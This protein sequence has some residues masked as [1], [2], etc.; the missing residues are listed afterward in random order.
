MTET[1]K[2]SS[3]DDSDRLRPIDPD[4][5]ALLAQSIEQG[6]L[7][8]PISVRA[9][10]DGYKLIVGGH[11]LA[12]V[13]NLGWEELTVGEHV[14]IRE[15][16]DD[17][18][19]RAEVDE[20]LVRH[21]LD[22]LDRALF[23]AKRQELYLKMA[24][25]RGRGGDRKS[26]KHKDEIKAQTLGFDFDEGFSANASKRFGLSKSA[27]ELAVG[28]AKKLSPE[29]IAAI[30]GT[31]V[32][33]NQ[34]ELL[35]L[36]DIKGDQQVAAAKLIQSGQAKTVSQAK[37]ALDPSLKTSVDLQGRLYAEILARLPKCDSATLKAVADEVK[38]EI[39]RKRKEGGE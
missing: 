1:I 21:D 30:R 24:R 35:A 17:D 37:I 6:R 3:I 28:L 23:F 8:Q 13:K 5:V 22:A 15:G 27:V 16:D 36:G 26:Q 34:Q 11:R 14:I 39:A 19:L 25:T 7:E 2:I 31:M 33:R 29:T 18:A 38:R 32:A 10:G 4:R 20:N 12:A 9:A